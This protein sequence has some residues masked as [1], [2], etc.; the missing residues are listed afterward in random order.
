MAE[1][2]TLDLENRYSRRWQQWGKEVASGKSVGELAESAMSKLIRTFRNLQRFFA[3]GNGVPLSA[4]LDAVVGDRGDIATI[5]R[6]ATYGGEYLQLFQMQAN[7]GLSREEILARVL[8]LTVERFAD[9]AEIKYVPDGNAN[10]SVTLQG[11]K[12]ELVDSIE[13]LAA[14]LAC[15]PDVR[16]NQPKKSTSQQESEEIDQ[17][18]MNVAA[19]SLQPRPAKPLKTVNV[20]F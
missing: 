4:V 13:A 15:D 3:E 11:V 9:Q 17:L 19:P 20:E 8:F 7:Q 5:I 2:E 1:N 12:E 16:L 14:R 6:N 18:S 10:L